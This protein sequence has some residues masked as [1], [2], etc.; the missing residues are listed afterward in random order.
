MH[1]LIFPMSQGDHIFPIEAKI[2]PM[3]QSSLKLHSGDEVNDLRVKEHEGDATQVGTE[4]FHGGREGVHEF[5][6]T[7]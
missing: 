1:D 7:V 5:P 2:D 3:N 4:F 6:K